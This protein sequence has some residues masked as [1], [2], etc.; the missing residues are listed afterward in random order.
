M[1]WYPLRGCVSARYWHA[2]LLVWLIDLFARSSSFQSV[3]RRRS[4]N[5]EPFWQTRV[6]DKSADQDGWSL[7]T[8]ISVSFPMLATNAFSIDALSL[9][10]II[11]NLVETRDLSMVLNLFI[12][13]VLNLSI[14]V[15]CSMYQYGP[16]RKPKDKKKQ[17]QKKRWG[18]GVFSLFE[19][20]LMNS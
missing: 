10:R 16:R 12:S 17:Q 20:L 14:V 2:T 1:V 7:R 8:T 15:A 9:A 4:F 6:P 3:L 5:Y 13:L 18:I 11:T 19:R